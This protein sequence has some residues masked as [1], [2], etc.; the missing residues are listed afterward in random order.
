MKADMD[1]VIDAFGKNEHVKKVFWTL[2]VMMAG[3]V[4]AWVVDPVTD[5]QVVRIITAMGCELITPSSCILH[6]RHQEYESL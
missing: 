2:F 3:L 5:Q 6:R 1:A 4:L